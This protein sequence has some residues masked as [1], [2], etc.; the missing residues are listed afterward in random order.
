MKNISVIIITKNEEH[1]IRECL[2]S[3]LWANEII[4]VDSGS[5]DSTLDIAKE[6][7]VKIIKKEWGGFAQQKSAALN[8]ATNKWVLS[9]DADERVTFGLRDEII[10]LNENEFSG[11]YIKR[12]NYFYKK[13]ITTC[14]WD[15]DKQ[16]RLF[17]KK[18]TSVTN[19]MVHEGFIVDGKVGILNNYI[20]HYTFRNIS[21]T[22]EKINHYS[23]LSAIEYKDKN[24]E[25]TI[26]KIIS[27]TI[28]AFLRYFF[29]LKGYKDGMH[30]F[31]ISI[32]NSLTTLLHYSKLW[33][34]KYNNKTN[35]L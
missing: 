3:V 11:Y 24:I 5:T 32:F 23:T 6:Y 29:S 25:V 31:L 4:V 26:V 14:G 16:I 12:E 33:E 13:K 17:V 8:A 15:K 28:S 9:I 20:L 18:K 2:E 7:G 30:G 27:H 34:I 1:N 21:S 22:I 35:Q 19:K 10:N